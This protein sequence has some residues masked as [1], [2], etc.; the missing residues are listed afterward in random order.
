MKAESFA[1]VVRW[2]RERSGVALGADK[3]YLV[4]NRL[5]PV[6]RRHG[7]ADLDALA[8][9]VRR[10]VVALERV[11]QHGQAHV[12]PRI[13]REQPNLFPELRLGVGWLLEVHQRVAEREV[14]AGQ[15]DAAFVVGSRRFEQRRVR[16]LVVA[17]AQQLSRGFRST[18]FAAMVLGTLS[19]LGGVTV[20]AYVE[21]APGATIVLLALATF[22]LTWPIGAW[23]RHRQRMTAPFPAGATE[24]AHTVVPEEHGH[25][26][27]EDCGHV[28]VPH[29]DHVDYVH[30]GHRHAP[31]GK[32]YDEH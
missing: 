29:G 9:A 20:S 8:D 4:E 3:L 22:A 5:A 16:F 7:L 1:A 17:T 21:V 18:L 28:A 10:G 26:H 12:G 15:R 27:G 23:L 31:H 11:E 2:F 6:A 24:E 13:E 14:E 32:H 25:E 30:D 19:A